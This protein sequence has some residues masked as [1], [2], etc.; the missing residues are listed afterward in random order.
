MLERM[1][2]TAFIVMVNIRWLLGNNPSSANQEAA[3][4]LIAYILIK[5]IFIFPTNLFHLNARNLANSKIRV[6]N[7][8]TC[9]KKVYST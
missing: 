3:F 4:S 8:A 7:M 2:K 5:L 6:L 9:L 1:D